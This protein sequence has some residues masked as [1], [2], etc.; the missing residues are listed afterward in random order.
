MHI[1]QLQQ[2]ELS[3]ALV[4]AMR[5][6]MRFEAP[7]YSAQGVE[8]FRR[9]IADPAFA[10]R[11]RCYGAFEGDTAVGMIATRSGGS[12]IALFF[13][14]EACQRRGIGRQLFAAVLAEAPDE[15]ITVNASPYAVP[16]YERLGFVALKEEQRTDGI[17]YTPMQRA[18][19][20]EDG[21]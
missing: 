4:L 10:G 1:R 17:R 16:V 13:V 5:V 19:R 7:D 20:R 2:T 21:A 14:E 9:T 6:F 15:A 11:I 12:H 18:I 3:A 8:S